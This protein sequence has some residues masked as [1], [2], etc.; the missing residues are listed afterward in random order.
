MGEGVVA[1]RVEVGGVGGE[2][3]DDE[4]SRG[5]RRDAQSRGAVAPTAR[6]PRLL[7][8]TNIPSNPHLVALHLSSFF[9][10]FD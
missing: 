6:S 2:L 5:R 1:M 3:V 8:N 7:P 10:L 4:R 9:C